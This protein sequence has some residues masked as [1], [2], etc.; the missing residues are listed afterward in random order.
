M[1][2]Q[3]RTPHHTNTS[4]DPSKNEK[5]RRDL[6]GNIPSIIVRL[7]DSLPSHL[8]HVICCVI[9]PSSHLIHHL[10]NL[11][12]KSHNESVK[13]SM[14][15]I[16]RALQCIGRCGVVP[17]RPLV[18]IA[19]TYSFATSSCRPLFA[20]GIYLG[21]HLSSLSPSQYASS[22]LLLFDSKVPVE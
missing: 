21:R 3:E 20:V 11:H 14:K 5:R 12:C 13:M 1:I 10:I 9:T 22:Y 7:S 4:W 15:G 6:L 17:P 2:H 16:G 19:R 8:S 18:H